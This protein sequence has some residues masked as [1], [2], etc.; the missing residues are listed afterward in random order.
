MI[1]PGGSLSIRHSPSFSRTKVK[2][3]ETLLSCPATSWYECRS[4]T[5]ATSCPRTVVETVVSV[6]AT[7]GPTGMVVDEST[8]IPAS[9]F[10]AAAA[11]SVRYLRA[12]SY[13]SSAVTASR[14]PVSSS[15]GLAP[16]PGATG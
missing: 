15:R 6:S 7:S 10:Q 13:P 8:R 5:L 11:V 12:V 9:G 14:N 3:D 1:T 4:S 16:L 2:S